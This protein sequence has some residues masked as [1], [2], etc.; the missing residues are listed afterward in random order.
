MSGLAF[1]SFLIGAVTGG[2]SVT[3][4]AAVALTTK[5]G[6]V[7]G[8]WARLATPAGR[9]LL[10]AGACGELVVDKLPQTPSRLTPPSLLGRAAFAATAA[11]LLAARSGEAPVRVLL[12]AVAGA[13][14][15]SVAGARW[16]AFAVR[17]GWH[18][19][20]AALLEDAVVVGLAAVTVRGD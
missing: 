19:L 4:L 7:A 13:L 3:G 18:P 2:R 6:A 14:S 17:H 8:L 12:P 16:R 15:G 9:A 20:A 5:P 10:T 11:A 1:R